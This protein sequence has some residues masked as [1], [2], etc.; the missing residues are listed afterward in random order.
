MERVITA[1]FQGAQA[2]RFDDALKWN[3]LDA[4]MRPT[5]EGFRM[6]H[7]RGTGPSQVEVQICLTGKLA[8]WDWRRVSE[9][10]LGLRSY[11]IVDLQRQFGM[12]LLYTK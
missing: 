6:V 2:A 8:S 7:I 9:Q 12:S 11:S 3:F 5:K 1:V 4:L 10:M